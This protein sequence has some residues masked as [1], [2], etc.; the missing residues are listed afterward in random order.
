MV[1]VMDSNTIFLSYSSEDFLFAEMLR[2]KLDE[3]GHVLWRDADQIVAGDS[4]RKSIEDGIAD[5][6]DWYGI[7][8]GHQ[9]SSAP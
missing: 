1:V 6:V 4:W 2:T 3:R 8:Y 7:K 9:S 5:F